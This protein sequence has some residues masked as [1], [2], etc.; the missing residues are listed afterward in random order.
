MEDALEA[1]PKMILPYKEDYSFMS[2]RF[3]TKQGIVYI[4]MAINCH[5]PMCE[6]T[7][8]NEIKSIQCISKTIKPECDRCSLSNP[9]KSLIG[10]YNPHK[11]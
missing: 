11:K 1:K 6:T 3:N 2:I 8:D 4:A 9:N 10:D 7:K 5:E